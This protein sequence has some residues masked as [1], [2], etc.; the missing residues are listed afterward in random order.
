MGDFN[1]NTPTMQGTEVFPTL[2]RTV[3]LGVNPLAGLAMRVV[4]GAVTPTAFGVF[5][6]DN[7]NSLH[8]CELVDTLLPTV[9]TETI[10]PGTDTGKIAAVTWVDETGAANAFGKVAKVND[11][12]T[13]LTMTGGVGDG[14][15]HTSAALGVI[16]NSINFGG[17][18]P[19]MYRGDRAAKYAASTQRVVSVTINAR[20]ANTD[21][22]NIFQFVIDGFGGGTTKLN[23]VS[24]PINPKTDG[25]FRTYSVTLPGD[26]WAMATTLPAAAY[27]NMPH[28]A[29]TWD[30]RVTTAG[31]Y[32]FGVMPVDRTGAGG[33]TSQF[34]VSGIWLTVNYCTENRR[35]CAYPR[36]PL[37][38][39]WNKLGNSTTHF[40]GSPYQRPIIFSSNSGTTALTTPA[41]ES[42]GAGDFVSAQDVGAT[43]VR[44]SDGQVV[45]TIS[46]VT[47]STTA[48]LT[49]NGASTNTLV[50]G[51]LGTAATNL[52]AATYYYAV[53]S[54]VSWTSK[55][56][57]LIDLLQDTALQVT[58]L[59][60]ATGIHRS[61]YNL[62]FTNTGSFVPAVASQTTGEIMPLLI[63]SGATAATVNAESQP[64]ASLSAING[65]EVRSG[66]GCA[67]QIT[68]P[69]VT[70]YLA[71]RV[72]VARFN[73]KKDPDQPL[74]I[75][76][77]HGGGSTTGGGTLDASA[78]IYPRDL[79]GT[80]RKPTTI[81]VPF[82]ASFNST[83][84]QYV[85]YFRSASTTGRG[86]TVVLLECADNLL[87]H[88][89]TSAELAGASV[90]GSTDAFLPNSGTASATMTQDSPAALCAPPTGLSNITAT[91]TAA[92]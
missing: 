67:Q 58:T 74:S 38:K 49:A 24:G 83:A 65:G 15:A 90:G 88:G 47:N 34:K 32:V 69:G 57:I 79:V 68:S 11:D 1:P 9:S 77:R 78:L 53:Q 35:A 73:D 31:P 59:A 75:E 26:P 48:V 52:T 8:G 71:V 39:G 54:Q 91:P 44:A 89:V 2:R 7:L 23:V 55:S 85:V 43:I 76:I 28:F 86:W 66:A 82:I 19:L 14:N 42:I 30:D 41:I 25:V 51:W 46:S 72:D 17:A 18:T 33:G 63:Y 16:A 81:E 4:P 27:W 40:A 20:I 56:K 61:V 84:T 22:A 5:E 64:Y 21:A 36:A 70:T 10:L 80:G 45:G 62:V 3:D 92:A 60:S 37:A 50:L 6:K 29:K 13:Y 12:S 87:G